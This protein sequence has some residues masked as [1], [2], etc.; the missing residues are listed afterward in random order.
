MQM[1]VKPLCNFNCK[2]DVIF[3]LLVNV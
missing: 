3:L 2:L 1:N